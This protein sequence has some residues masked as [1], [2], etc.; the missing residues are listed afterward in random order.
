LRKV[1]GLLLKKWPKGEMEALLYVGAAQILYMDDVPDFAAVNETVEAAKECE[2]PNIVKTVNAVL[3]N[4]IRR[5]EEFLSMLALAPVDERESFPSQLYRR[6]VERYGEENAIALA[7]W[8]NEPAETFL[9]YPDRFEKLPRGVRVNEIDGYAQGRFIVQDP[10]TALAIEMLNIEAGDKVFD[11]CAAPGG[12]TIQIAWRGAEVVACEIKSARRRRLVENLKR[13][14]LHEKVGVVSS[15]QAVA[16]GGFKKILVDA[17]CTNTGV[18]RRRPDA[19]WNWS[20]EKLSALAALQSQILDQAAE[21]CPRGGMIVYSTCSNEPEENLA[22]VEA[23][24][25]RHCGFSLVAS[26]ESIPF[27]SGNDGAFAAALIRK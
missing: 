3:R 18:L 8:H 11:M 1:L 10:A 16:A 17:P 22:Q 2:N 27:E 9:A 24:L 14:G 5:R 6:W 15:P 26:R 23:F 19:R 20:M 4:L 25:A 21:L 12:K 7:K 13:V